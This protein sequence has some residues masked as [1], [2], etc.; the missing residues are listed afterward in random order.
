ML[1]PDVC[2][3]FTGLFAFG[4][5]EFAPVCA[6]LSGACEP[7]PT[8][9]TGGDFPG[10]SGKVVTSCVQ[11]WGSLQCKLTGFSL[12]LS[13]SP[14]PTG[15]LEPEDEQCKGLRLGTRWEAGI[16]LENQFS[17]I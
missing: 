9:A 3:V 8:Q 10:C 12:A 6:A 16:P 7:D 11:K 13:Q 17:I 4:S 14:F 5:T 15:L 2:L 1:F